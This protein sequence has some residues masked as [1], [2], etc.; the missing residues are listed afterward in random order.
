[1][2]KKSKAVEKVLLVILVLIILAVIMVYSVGS[3]ALKAGIETAA[4][5]ALNVAVNIDDLD[6]S[7]FQGRVS[8][9]DVVIDNPPGYEYDKLLELGEATV[10]V[11]IGS[12][13]SDTVNVREIILDGV[14]V[15][16]EQKGLSNNLQEVINSIPK[17][18]KKPKTG[19]EK[20][21][22][23]LHIDT[24][25][26]TNVTVNVKLLPIPGKADTISLKLASIRMTNLD[27]LDTAQLT[28]KILLAIAAGIAEQGSGLLPAEMTAGM[29]EAARF[30]EEGE[31]IIEQGKSIIEGFKGLLKPKK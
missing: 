31:K 28:G 11:G 2:A 16:V 7:I 15:V 5:K 1:M 25:E 17:S 10:A 14:N 22:K 4:S 29:K 30:A 21:G 23:T 9:E 27:G 12:L 20:P 8:F 18:E 6:L 13:L 26:I 19:T 3:S 24:L